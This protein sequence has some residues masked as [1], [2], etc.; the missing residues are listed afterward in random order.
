MV[1]SRYIEISVPQPPRCEEATMSKQS[2]LSR[3]HVLAG[4]AAGFAAAVLPTIGFA[5]APMANSQ[6][7]AYYRFRV[8]A[9]EAT[10]VSDGPLHMGEP[11]G[12]VFAGVS[13][14]QMT[15]ELTDN[16]LPTDD[17]LLEQ[18]ALV[19]NS[20]ER[21][22]LFDTGGFKTMGPDAGRLIAN[23]KASGIEAKDVDAVVVTHAHP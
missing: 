21:V 9:F 5:K 10:V 17:V 16:F 19:I 14:E 7:P 8:G 18:N 4:S 6:A 12:N 11:S 22:V 20:G 3:R 1:M 23:L 13:K 2:Q 15:K